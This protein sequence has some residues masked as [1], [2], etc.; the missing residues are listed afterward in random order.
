MLPSEQTDYFF[1]PQPFVCLPLPYRDSGNEFTRSS[2]GMTVSLMS[3]NGVPYGRWGRITA[4]IITT[5][6]FRTE[7]L[8]L[9][10]YSIYGLLACLGIK[11][12]G[13]YRLN[14]FTETMKK[15]SSLTIHAATNYNGAYEYITIALTTHGKIYLE[16]Q[17]AENASSDL[18]Y[19]DLTKEGK[20]YLCRTAVPGVLEHVV[21]ITSP[22]ELDLYFWL[23]RKLYNSLSRRSTMPDF[24]PWGSIYTQ[25]GSGKAMPPTYKHKFRQEVRSQLYDIKK[26]Y[27]PKANI[28]ATDEG[29]FFYPSPNLIAPKDKAATLLPGIFRGQNN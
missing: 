13:G 22:R 18:S 23:V 25:F 20:A 17:K 2:G 5:E 16:K 28:R 6:A 27:Y 3:P 1:T 7:T 29:I 9:Q 11:N 19:I 4:C 14:H 24:V 21:D 10:F 12:T 8:R 26:K 15:W